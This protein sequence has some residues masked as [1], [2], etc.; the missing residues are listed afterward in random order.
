MKRLLL[1]CLFTSCFVYAH[2]QGVGIGTT[3]PDTSAALDVTSSSKG[4]LIPRMTQQQRTNIGTTPPVGLMVY[5]TDA[6]EGFYY[7]SG[8]G[9]VN[10]SHMPPQF[11]FHNYP[12][13]TTNS[14]FYYFS[15]TNNGYSTTIDDNAVFFVPVGASVTISVNMFSNAVTPSGT[16]NIRAVVPNNPIGSWQDYGQVGIINTTAGSTTSYKLRNLGG[17]GQFFTIRVNATYYGS[18][19]FGTSIS[20]Q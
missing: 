14:T 17:I 19:A 20:Y 7:Y 5:Q 13:P 6:P 3:T 16:L 2:A 18:A 12:T 8:T 15:P 9:W 4:M 1:L 10:V 11:A